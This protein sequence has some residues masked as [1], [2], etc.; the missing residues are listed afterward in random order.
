[1]NLPFKVCPECGAEHV[2]AALVCADCNVALELAPAGSGEPATAP[3]PPAPELAHVAAGGPWEMERLALALQEAG[4]S[5]RI[6]T[7]PSAQ[8]TSR[9]A[10]GAAPRGSP[11]SGARLGLYVL[12]ADADAARLVI[13]GILLQGGAGGV[14]P[15]GER[16]ALDACPACG[17]PISAAASACSD[18]GLEFVPVEDVCSRCGAV[19]DGEAT[20]CPGCGARTPPRGAA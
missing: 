18:C 5:S 10:A 14:S 8:P 11:G 12:P 9:R 3:L 7:S 1:M 17:A 13:Q 19:L 4:I 2:H 6:D 20:V 15:A 16:G